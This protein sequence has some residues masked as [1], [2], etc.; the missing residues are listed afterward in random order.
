MFCKPTMIKVPG[1]GY[2]YQVCAR[3]I[4]GN[5]Q[6]KAA[7]TINGV[8]ASG[9]SPYIPA[10]RGG[11][12]NVGDIKISALQALIP[13]LIS[14]TSAS[15][16]GVVTASSFY[17]GSY[18]GNG[19]NYGL[20]LYDL[21]K[22]MDDDPA[23][24]WSTNTISLGQYLQWASTSPI[25]VLEFQYTTYDYLYSLL[26]YSDDGSTWSSASE[27]YRDGGG[28]FTHPTTTGSTPHYYWRIIVNQVYGPTISS[29]YGYE[30]FQL[31]GQ[32]QPLL[33][34]VAVTASGF[35]SSYVP[36]LAIDGSSGTL[37]NSGGFA[38]QWIYV[39]LGAK[40]PI[41]TVSVLAG[42]GY[43]VGITYYD[44]QV[45]DDAI[46]WVTVAKASS[47]TAWGI[48]NVSTSARYVRLYVTSH[49]SGSWIALYEFQVY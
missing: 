13:T 31:Y 21:Y 35:Y 39:D 41:S 8:Q 14:A 15:G 2:F 36:A 38:P 22:A 5:I 47:S 33:T 46:S 23:T 44:I 17:K 37:W 28:R 11:V 4:V 24:R 45:S 6:V 16:V 29:W 18:Y 43:P 49:S 26:E 34:P 10:V 30:Q 3:S 9:F 12:S 42:S 25:A 27:I 7:A 1:L 40:R 48:T 32:T 19:S 20:P